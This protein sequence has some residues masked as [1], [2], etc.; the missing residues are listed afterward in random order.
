VKI[1]Q[2]VAVLWALMLAA[3]ASSTA[4]EKLIAAQGTDMMKWSSRP[5]VDAAITDV[6]Q[7]A[8]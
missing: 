4:C 7:L 6:L 8:P 3:D 5:A 1:G 2:F